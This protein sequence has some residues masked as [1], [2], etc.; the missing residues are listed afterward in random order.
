[1]R[2]RKKTTEKINK[3]SKPKLKTQKSSK[4]INSPSSEGGRFRGSL[5]RGPECKR[6]TEAYPKVKQRKADQR[7]GDGRA[8]DHSLEKYGKGA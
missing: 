7:G 5:R 8:N 4:T 6:G 3:T 1:M 2:M